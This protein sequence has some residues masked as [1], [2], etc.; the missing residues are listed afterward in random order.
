MAIDREKEIR[1]LQEQIEFIRNSAHPPGYGKNLT[2][3]DGA[4]Q[5]AELERKIAVQ[6]E[7]LD[8]ERGR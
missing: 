3:G 8:K 1:E 5:I 2:I 6:R 4:E 7:L